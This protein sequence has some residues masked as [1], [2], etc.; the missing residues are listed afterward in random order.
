M[1]SAI[2]AW[3]TVGSL[4]ALAMDCQLQDASQPSTQFNTAK[5]VGLHLVVV[6]VSKNNAN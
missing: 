5:N 6:S 4:G 2:G 1:A 3:F